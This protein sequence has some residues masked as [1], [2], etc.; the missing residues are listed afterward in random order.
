MTGTD[1]T[2]TISRG[3]ILCRLEG[4]GAAPEALGALGAHICAHL[5]MR[6]ADDGALPLPDPATL[7][8]LVGPQVAAR[9]AVDAEGCRLVLRLRA[10]E[11]ADEAAQSPPR[12]APEAARIFACAD[13]RMSESPL[14]QRRSAHRHLRAAL[15]WTR[16]VPGAGEGPEA[17]ADDT[18]YRGDLAA[19]GGDAP[20]PPLRLEP[21]QRVDPAR[22]VAGV[23]PAADGDTGFAAFAEEM[24]ATTLPD[25]LEAAA[26]WL[27]DVRGRDAFPRAVLLETLSEADGAAPPLDEALGACARMLRAGR[28]EARPGGA[29][30][31]TDTTRFRRA[32][33][34][35]DRSDPR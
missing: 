23:D 28:L 34:R 14:R 12:D 15:A 19:A 11:D 21:S 16:A 9:I 29:L 1:D 6:G 17:G 3:A 35:G 18:P 26:A 13:S 30:A 22:P 27:A 5:A 31:P 24:G 7:A 25:R 10:A 33:R 2:L 20:L 32:A 4:F 8:R